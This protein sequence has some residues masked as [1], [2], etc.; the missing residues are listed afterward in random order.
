MTRTVATIVRTK[1]FIAAIAAGWLLCGCASGGGGTASGPSS[2]HYEQRLTPGQAVALD[3]EGSIGVDISIEPSQGGIVRLDATR[4]RGL[5]GLL[6][7]HASDAKW[8]RLRL[9]P[10]SGSAKSHWHFGAGTEAKI[11]LGVP[12]DA[13]VTVEA[14]NG[15]VRS[16]GVRGPL[17]IHIV[18]GPIE[19][20]GAGSVLSLHLVNGPIAVEVADQSRTPNIDIS[21]TNGSINVT[22]PKGF[23]A[24]VDAHTVIGPLDERLSGTSGPGSMSVRLVT[25][26]ITIEER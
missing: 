14:V 12:A 17:A 6:L 4:V 13:T 10:T 26:P 22:V 2:V 15:P 8:L 7:T 5:S 3:T 23:R 19:V 21:A 18:N 16:S 9:E 24:M 25:G 20:S 11:T 1:S